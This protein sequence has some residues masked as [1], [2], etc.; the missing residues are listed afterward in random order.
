[1]G[2]KDL[3]VCQSVVWQP[4][5]FTTFYTSPEFFALKRA[6]AV[7]LP[8]DNTFRT[9]IKIMGLKSFLDPKSTFDF[10]YFTL[11]LWW[12]Y[13]RRRI[14][15]P[16]TIRKTTDKL[17]GRYELW[18]VSE[19]VT[20]KIGPRFSRSRTLLEIDLTYICSLR[21]QGCNRS[22]DKAPSNESISLAQ[23]RQFIDE[24][25][26]GGHQWESIRILGGE[27]TLHP[28]FLSVLEALR[29]Y[30]RTHR[31]RLRLTV[32]TNGHSPRT[33]SILEKIPCDVYV[34]NTSKISNVQVDFAPF[35]NAPRDYSEHAHSDFRNGCWVTQGLGM[36]FTPYGYYHCAIAGG[37][38]RIYNFNLGRRSIPSPEDAMHDQFKAFC[39]LCGHFCI[40]RPETTPT[41]GISPSWRKA[42]S[43]W[44]ARQKSAGC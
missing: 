11:P 8:S 26:A 3:F 12:R 43:G 25:V 15:L 35:N 19:N 10:S 18:R 16:A 5:P 7:V 32:V 34:E 33:K 2:K 17:F 21:C 22:I 31:P 6:P 44:R 27:P 23:I 28:E 9:W 36:G 4:I 24:S 1:L 13:E 29:E 14:A 38:D 37:I 30:R 20:R 40:S 42:Y 41:D 39:S